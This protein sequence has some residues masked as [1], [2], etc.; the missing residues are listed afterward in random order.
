MGDFFTEIEQRDN[1]KKPKIVSAIAKKSILIIFVSLV[2]F[3]ISYLT[4][5]GMFIFLKNQTTTVQNV[6]VS[7]EGPIREVEK[8]Y[9]FPP[10]RDN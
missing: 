6:T 10:K 1:K 8:K 2:F 4:Y 7:S 9:C 5:L 3:T